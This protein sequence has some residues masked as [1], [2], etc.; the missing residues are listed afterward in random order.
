MSDQ[1]MPP[2]QA[3]DSSSNDPTHADRLRALLERADLSQRGAA[4]LLGIDERTVRMWCAGQGAP[5]E[6]VYRALDPRLT[7]SEHLCQRIEMN[8][9]QIELLE[10]GRFTEL[11][12]AYRPV[13]AEAAKQEIGHL[14]GRNEK[15]RSILRLDEAFYR[16][17]EA[18]AVVFQQWLAAGF[19]PTPANLQT[20][21]AADREF[22]LAKAN[23]DR[24]TEEIRA[25]RR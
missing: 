21:D 25:G 1:R 15:Y 16:M 23:V 22:Q 6:S 20:F 11:P 8:E 5:P 17:R 13:D 9:R 7:Y 14:R 12:R 24:V 18:H 3:D 4:R 10:N 2:F 19:G